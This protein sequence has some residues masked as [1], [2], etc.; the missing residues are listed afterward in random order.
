MERHT[1]RGQPDTG[2]T[3]LEVMIA[4]IILSV[5]VLGIIA[6]QVSTYK[7]LQTSHNYAYAAMLANDMADRILANPGNDAAYE[8]DALPVGAPD[9]SGLDAVCDSNLMVLHDIN[10][11]QT[12]VQ[13]LIPGTNKRQ[14]G[15]LPDGR[16]SVDFIA[17]PPSSI[18]IVVRWD[19]DLSGST[20]DNC[21]HLTG[22]TMS[23]S[24]LDCFVLTL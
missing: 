9:C 21:V 4:L 6:L 5:G 18:N 15:S 22:I 14:P 7:S 8:H 2:F 20:G 11:W 1:T 13:G 12:L 16:G 19:D 17:G 23:A 24:D 3:L 10:E